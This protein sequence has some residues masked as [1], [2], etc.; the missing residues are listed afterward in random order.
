MYTPSFL[1]I[2]LAWCAVVF[3]SSWLRARVPDG[4]LDRV[5]AALPWVTGAVVLLG[6]LGAMTSLMQASPSDAS[7]A[8]LGVVRESSLASS[9]VVLV[10]LVVELGITALVW[11]RRRD[12]SDG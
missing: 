4:A 6:Q 2:F 7:G 8:P 10:A 11:R 9:A 1:E 12:G 5:L 3:W